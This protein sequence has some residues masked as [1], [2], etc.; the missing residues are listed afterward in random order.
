MSND[1]NLH[2]KHERVES[3]FDKTGV[4]TGLAV[5]PTEN[6]NSGASE[7]DLLSSTPIPLALAPLPICTPTNYNFVVFEYPET[8]TGRVTTTMTT[9]I[10]DPGYSTFIQPNPNAHSVESIGIGGSYPANN[11]SDTLV[12]TLT[13][14]KII[15]F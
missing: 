1:I 5:E 3:T 9:L 2:F 13:S 10:T 6:P 12:E 4:S 8:G 14:Q 15:L 7:F 11:N